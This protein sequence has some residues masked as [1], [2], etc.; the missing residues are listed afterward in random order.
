M[1]AELYL[2]VRNY[3]ASSIMAAGLP[4]TSFQS[5]NETGL[6]SHNSISNTEEQACANDCNEVL[7]TVGEMK[8]KT[9]LRKECRHGRR[10]TEIGSKFARPSSAQ[11]SKIIEDSL[12]ALVG[13]RGGAFTSPTNSKESSRVL[14]YS[15][16]LLWYLLIRRPSSHVN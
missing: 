11:K 1:E 3:Q 5:R 15:E 2:C 16:Y 10:G 14:I 6:S 12:T 13:T 8:T 9:K 4:K 7:L